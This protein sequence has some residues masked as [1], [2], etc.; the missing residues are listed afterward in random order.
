M[1]HARTFEI[2]YPLAIQHARSV[3][4]ACLATSQVADEVAHFRRRGRLL[5]HGGED[6]V[7]GKG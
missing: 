5:L 4:H 3:L 2:V 1:R 6:L 7:E